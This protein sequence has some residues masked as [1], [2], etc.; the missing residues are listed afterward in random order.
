MNTHPYHLE[1]H[2]H[3]TSIELLCS[4]IEQSKLFYTNLLGLS[5]LDEDNNRIVLGTTKTKILT[6]I[7][8]NDQTTLNKTLGL[9]HFALLLP[10]A[11]SL[12]AAIY[13]LSKNNYPMSGLTDHG[14]SIALYLNDPDGNGIELYIDRQKE[15]WP[16]INGHLNMYTKGLHD[17]VI[18]KELPNEIP[19]LIDD[20]TI[21]GH[22]HFFV[23]NL[24]EVKQ[25]YVNVLGFNQMQSYANS[26]L[27]VSDGNY[28]HHIG[29]N[30][31]Q[32]HALPRKENEV[33]LISYHLHIPK[34]NFDIVKQK[35]KSY[36]IN[37]DADLKVKDPLGQIIYLDVQEQK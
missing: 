32:K 22:L 9:Y 26:A 8:G 36:G 23:S 31:W 17:N 1:D 11:S 19:K 21:I 37:L 30:N 35:L 24:A 34:I 13:R 27:F 2:M 20:K 12:A 6:L 4:D 18:M 29:L 14:V 28:H 5:I 16:I 33:G 15:D 25:F 3:I 10:N 7:M